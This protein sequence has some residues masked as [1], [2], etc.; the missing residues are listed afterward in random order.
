MAVHLEDITIIY[1]SD[2]N[3][4]CFVDNDVSKIAEWD[5]VERRSRGAISK[6]P[7]N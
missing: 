1:W 7:Q 3:S 6:S 4:F 2:P 5:K